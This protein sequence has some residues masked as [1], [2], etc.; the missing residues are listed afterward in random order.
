MTLKQEGR[1]VETRDVSTSRTRCFPT[2]ERHLCWSQGNLMFGTDGSPVKRKGHKS[3]V[4]RSLRRLDLPFN[5]DE[6]SFSQS[7]EEF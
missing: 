6:S 7:T 1:D 2:T 3:L 4:F 5:Y